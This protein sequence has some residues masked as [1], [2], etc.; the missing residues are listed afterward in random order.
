MA[1]I[2]VTGGRR[3]GFV[4][5]YTPLDAYRAAKDR[6]DLERARFDQIMDAAIERLKLTEVASG[7]CRTGAD[8]LAMRWAK[9]RKVQFTGF[10]A[11]WQQLGTAAGPERNGRMLREFRPDKVLAFPG[12]AGTADCVRQA[13]ALGIEV[14]RIDWK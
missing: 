11:N 10:M 3:Y 5:A 1:R 8:E 4:P 9:R 13:E 7:R 14:I 6:A 2:V 12:G